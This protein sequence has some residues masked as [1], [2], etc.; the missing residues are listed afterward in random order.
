MAAGTGVYKPSIIQPAWHQPGLQWPE[1][2]IPA[3]NIQTLIASSQATKWPTPSSLII[4]SEHD[5]CIIVSSFLRI[6]S[7]IV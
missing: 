4:Y 6:Q 2:A 1:T 7:L 3:S 5:F